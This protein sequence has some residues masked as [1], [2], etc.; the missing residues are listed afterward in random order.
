MVRELQASVVPCI[1]RTGFT[2][3]FPHFRRIG[4]QSIDLLTFQFDRN[5]GGF[6]V[7]I[8]RCPPDGVVTPW[9]ERIGPN[10]VKAWDLNP[11]RR[12]RVVVRETGRVE[13]WFRF[14][15]QSPHDLSLMLLGKLDAPDLWDGLGP[16][17]QPNEQHRML[18][19]FREV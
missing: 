11:T 5:G 15:Q 2:G 13:D 19:H 1:R 7:E 12:R 14:D 8:A 16:F 18:E 6:L 10:K 17:G 9:G 3:S 4:V